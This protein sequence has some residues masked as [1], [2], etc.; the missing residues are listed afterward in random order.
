MDHHGRDKIAAVERRCKSAPSLSLRR[1]DDFGPDGDIVIG[2]GC[3]TGGTGE[4]EGCRLA[5]RPRSAA[6]VAQ[7]GRS[8]LQCDDLEMQFAQRN[9]GMTLPSQ[10]GGIGSPAQRQSLR[11]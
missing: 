7:S 2:P 6:Q 5:L 4:E 9:V 11:L 8:T 1:R 10:C 3:R